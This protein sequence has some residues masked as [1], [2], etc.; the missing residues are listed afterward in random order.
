MHP[1]ALAT[2]RDD[3]GVPQIGQMPGDLWLALSQ[4]FDKVADANLAAGHQVQKAQPGV[5]G[6]CREKAG[7]VERFGAT[8]HIFIVYGLT[9]MKRLNIFA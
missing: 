4:D 3:A 5:V 6:Q 9:N 2:S 7:Q 8:I 1:L